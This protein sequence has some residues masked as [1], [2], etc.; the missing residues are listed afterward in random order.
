MGAIEPSGRRNQKI[1]TRRDILDATARL[2]K[3]GPTP[4]LDEIAEEAKVSRA[5]AYRYFP[6]V[7]AL[8]LEALLDVRVPTPAEFFPADADPDPAARL[9][10]VDAMFH[11]LFND[12]EA[13]FRALLA[14]T[15]RAPPDDGA[16]ATPRRQNRRAPL[17]DMALEPAEAEF[18]PEALPLLKGSV[19]LMIALEG[20]V[21]AK[22]VLGLSDEESR[23]IKRWAIRAL[24][25]AARKRP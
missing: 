12:N 10:R 23:A 21:V 19:A 5:T 6:G 20:M 13:M 11:D 2:L 14:Q 3:R 9:E 4:T 25:E 1:R 7:E 24:I 22:D 18:D 15:V 8:L 16:A 17:I